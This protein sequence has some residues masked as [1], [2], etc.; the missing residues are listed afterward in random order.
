[1]LHIWWE[2]PQ[3]RDFWNRVLLLRKLTQLSTD[4]QPSLALLNE[5]PPGWPHS[6]KRLVYFAL[7]AAKIVIAGAWKAPS[8]SFR[9]LKHIIQWI[10]I[11]E[12]YAKHCQMT[13]RPSLKAPGNHRKCIATFPSLRSTMQSPGSSSPALSP[14]LIQIFL[15]SLDS[16]LNYDLFFFSSLFCYSLCFFLFVCFSCLIM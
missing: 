15:S 2:C 16:H 4:Q 13:I 8:V 3:L 12:K 14:S 5:L 11:H 10:M 9:R 6:L 7:L 1:M